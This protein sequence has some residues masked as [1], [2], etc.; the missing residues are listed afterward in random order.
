MKPIVLASSSPRRSEL[1]TKHNIDFMIEYDS[2]EEVLD[3]SLTLSMRLEKLAYDKGVMVAK[4]HLDKIVI[5]ADTMVCLGQTMLGKAKDRNEA[6]TMLQ[7]QSGRV[8]TVYTAIAIFENN[9]VTTYCDTTDVWFKDLSEKDIEKYLDS[10]E[11]IGKAGAYAI[12]GIGGSLVERISG[13]KETIIGL[14]VRII[15]E[16][17]RTK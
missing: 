14:P 10:N 16:Y 6:K 12:Q 3:E 2:I 15:E 13:D 5:S 1:L 4:R 11:W 7:K 9:Q 17:L 8:Q